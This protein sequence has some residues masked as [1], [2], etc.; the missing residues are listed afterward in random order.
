MES[1]VDPKLLSGVPIIAEM[2]VGTN[3]GNVERVQHS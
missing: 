2:S 3:W 1:V